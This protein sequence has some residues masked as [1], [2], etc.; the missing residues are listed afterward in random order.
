MNETHHWGW[1]IFAFA[2]LVTGAYIFT[3]NRADVYKGNALHAEQHRQ[4]WPFSIHIGEG[5]CARLDSFKPLLNQDK[6]DVKN[7]I[8]SNRVAH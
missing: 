5:G 1:I 3:L 6:K 7:N 2:V 8:D 4:D